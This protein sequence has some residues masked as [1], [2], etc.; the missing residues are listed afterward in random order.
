MK[1]LT[2]RDVMTREILEV[3]AD[4]SLDRLAEFF[5]ENCVSG[6]PVSSED[7]KL[8][9]VVSL[10]DIISHDTLPEKDPQSNGTHE[11]YLYSLQ[12]RYAQVDKASFCIRN[13]PLITVGDIMTPTIFKVNEDTTV[14]QIADTMIRGRIHRIFVTREEKVLG[15]ISALDMLKVIQDM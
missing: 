4:W 10:T 7:G 12:H 11:Y 3:R 15:I 5:V 9:G 14:Q 6:A 1:E 8:I 2:A 13:E